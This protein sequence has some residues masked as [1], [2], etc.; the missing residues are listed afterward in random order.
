MMLFLLF[1]KWRYQQLERLAAYLKK[2]NTGDYSL[3]VRDNTEGELSILKNE[4]YKATVMLQ[5]QNNALHREKLFMKEA[6]SD[7]SH[8]LK[9]PLT[10][11]FMM[12]DLLCDGDLPEQK[13]MEFTD[14]IRAQLERLQWLVASLL[15]LSKL[16]AGTI[17]FHQQKVVPKELIEKA[18]APLIIPMELKQQKLVIE[19]DDIS[20]L[21]DVNWTVEALV[22]ILKNCVEHT[23]VGGQI[24]ISCSS[25][26]LRST[27]SI[28]DEG[29]GIH[30]DDLPYIFNR[31]Y[32]GKH[33]SNDSVGIGLAMAWSIISSQGG[34]LEVRNNHTQGAT[35]YVRLVV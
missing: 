23:P 5:E 1:T 6:L 8:Q 28:E 20:L 4:I 12:T 34:H 32:K 15:K 29:P 27:I 33:A 14:R 31:F 3:D 9:T 35:F 16:D 24:R 11:M 10:S 13:R 7:I 17:T 19:T 30:R 18:C 2:I 22:N 25:N 21:C 26:P